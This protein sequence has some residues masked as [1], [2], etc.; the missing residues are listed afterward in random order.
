MAEEEEK[1]RNC[2]KMCAA[3]WL[4][5]VVCAGL[6]SLIWP[7]L[8]KSLLCFFSRMDCHCFKIYLLEEAGVSRMT[9]VTL[10]ILKRLIN[11]WIL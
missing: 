2:I 7:R 9:K 4:G 5:F 11:I 10:W 3:A 8:Q 6:V 1:N